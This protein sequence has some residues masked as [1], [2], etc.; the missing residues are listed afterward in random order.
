[1]SAD[2]RSATT[3]IGRGTRIEGCV[4][5]SG[6]LLVE[7]S[8]H[9]DVRG[10]GKAPATLA[11]GRQGSIVGSVAAVDV[12]SE[13]RI[14]GTVSAAGAVELLADSTTSGEISYESLR[15]RRGAVLDCVLRPLRTEA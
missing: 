10:E 3:V 9:G 2:A 1:M 14:E 7:G 13:G 11:L 6:A 4:Q 8:V 5:F 12:R 15:V